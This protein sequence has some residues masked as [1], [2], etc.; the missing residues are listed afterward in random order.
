MGPGISHGSMRICASGV[1]NVIAEAD[2][3][4][5]FPLYF[6]GKASYLESSFFKTWIPDSKKTF[7]LRQE[8]YA[9]RNQ[10]R[11][12]YLAKPGRSCK[13]KTNVF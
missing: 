7:R 6:L 10:T 1:L 2:F 9:G 5:N 8:G 13:G 4:K 12:S 11:R 3:T